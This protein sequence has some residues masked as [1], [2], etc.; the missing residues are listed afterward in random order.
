MNSALEQQNFPDPASS[1]QTFASDPQAVIEK[2][3]NPYYQDGV[4]VGYTAP[5]KWWNWLWNHIS[6]WLAASKTDRTAMQT[7][8]LNVLSAASITPSSSN[9]HQ[10]SKGIDGVC[11]NTCDAYNNEETAETI[12]GVEV[13][14]KVNQPYVVGYTL[15]I[16]ESELL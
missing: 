12:G 3:G 2:P 1:P 10:L 14:H 8:M 4:D 5:A 11:Y 9:D 13:T 16:P 6:A 7:E 15:Y